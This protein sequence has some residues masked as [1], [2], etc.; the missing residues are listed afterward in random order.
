MANVISFVVRNNATTTGISNDT[1]KL[2][3]FTAKIII[4]YEDKPDFI[5]NLNYNSYNDIDVE[6]YKTVKLVAV[7]NNGY[8]ISN[9]YRQTINNPLSYTP[10]EFSYIFPENLLVAGSAW[11]LRAFAIYT[12]VSSVPILKYTIKQ[13]DI[14]LLTL[15]NVSLLINGTSAS[16]GREVFV[17]DVLLANSNNKI[18]SYIR[19]SGK[20]TAGGTTNL[21]FTLNSSKK[22]AN[23]TMPNNS[24]TY[25]KLELVVN[26]EPDTYTI[27]ETDITK[28]NSNLITLY[29]NNVQA[30]AGTLINRGDSIRGVINGNRI[31]KLITIGTTP[32][33]SLYFIGKSTGG[34]NRYLGFNISENSKEISGN[35][36]FSSTGTTWNSL[37]ISTDEVAGVQPTNNVYIV[38]N[39]NITAIS[40]E[41]YGFSGAETPVDYGQFI[42]N[43]ISIPF[44]IS[45]N[46]IGEDKKVILGNKTTTVLVPTLLEDRILFNLGEIDLTNLLTNSL[47]LKNTTCIIHLPRTKPI[48]ID[49]NYCLGHKISINYYLDCYTGNA[50][51]DLISSKIDDVFYSTNV[52]IGINIPFIQ[53]WGSIQKDNSDI[54]LGSYVNLEKCYIEI[55]RNE[56]ILKNGFFTAPITAESNLN[57]EKGFIQIENINLNVTATSN[58]KDMILTALRSGVIIND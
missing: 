26:N 6:G 46:I 54:N 58:E 48:E 8:E 22:N 1:N 51:I 31:F 50:Q 25:T 37:E 10:T 49:I 30:V 24:N 12:A 43:I 40:A 21:N 52:D 7:P 9:A 33:S 23:L 57:N 53:T 2:K 27:S 44:K 5:K 11:T 35:F 55:V 20:D 45:N 19:F 32:Y 3:E 14:D 42:L 15:N 29:V 18:F 13:T 47:D 16:V 4:S 34:Q 39:D 28:L 41:R 38:T 56:A 17:N 36:T